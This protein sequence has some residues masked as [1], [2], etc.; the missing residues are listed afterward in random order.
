MQ[1]RIAMATRLWRK[2]IL[3]IDHVSLYLLSVLGKLRTFW[4]DQFVWRIWTMTT[5]FSFFY[6]EIN[7]IL[8]LFPKWYHWTPISKCLINLMHDQNCKK[9]SLGDT[10]TENNNAYFLLSHAAICYLSGQD[11]AILSSLEIV[12]VSFLSLLHFML[13][14]NRFCC[15]NHAKRWIRLHVMKV[16]PIVSL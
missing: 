4:N 2:T 7:F 6:Y 9:K 14:Y 1:I 13:K 15:R 5:R 8:V 10:G 3:Q 11:G 12:H 16:S